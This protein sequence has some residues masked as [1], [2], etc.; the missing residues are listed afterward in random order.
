[1]RGVVEILAVMAAGVLVG[2][3]VFPARLKGL[4]E[5]LTLAVT[6]LLIFS[7]GVLLAGRD[8]FL[9]ELGQ[10]GMGQHPVLPCAGGVLDDR[11]VRADEPVHVRHRPASG[12]PACVCGAG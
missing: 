12:G 10:V 6:G 8:S 11:R 3:T 9:E 4:N 5:K 1:E 7:M 2:A